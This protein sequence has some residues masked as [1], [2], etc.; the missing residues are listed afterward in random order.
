MMK[1]HLLKKRLYVAVALNQGE[2][3]NK[4]PF[5]IWQ[6]KHYDKLRQL[7]LLSA[8]KL[9]YNYNSFVLL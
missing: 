2:W 6:N 1:D 4:S 5:K 9:I 8:I 3:P 7:K